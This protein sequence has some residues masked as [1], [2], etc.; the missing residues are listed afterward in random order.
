MVV[1]GGGLFFVSE[2][3][4]LSHVRKPATHAR[5]ALACSDNSFSESRKRIMYLT[6]AESESHVTLFV[7]VHTRRGGVRCWGRCACRRA[8]HAWVVKV[9]IAV[10]AENPHRI[11]VHV[12][13]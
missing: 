4:L 9:V 1:L 11:Q 13:Q 3:P 12:D 10:L 6:L 7:T 2:V 5:Q 8:M